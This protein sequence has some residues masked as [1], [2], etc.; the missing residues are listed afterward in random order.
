MLRYCYD[1]LKGLLS[2]LRPSEK[3][4]K[5]ALRKGKFLSCIL[6]IFSA[7]QKYPAH[8]REELGIQWNALV[9]LLTTVIGMSRP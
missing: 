7:N 6:R 9:V 4:L 5:P 3:L 2:S 1:H 8:R